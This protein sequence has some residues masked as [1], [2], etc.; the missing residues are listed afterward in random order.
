MRRGIISDSLEGKE[1][2]LEV[3]VMR[4]K[5][6]RRIIFVLV[7]LL[8][9]SLCF[10]EAS[11][12]RKRSK[13]SRRVTNPVTVTPVAEPQQPGSE[14]QII[15]TADQQATGQNDASDA[16]GQA[17]KKSQRTS[18]P[19]PLPQQENE[20]DSMRRTVNDLTNQVTKLSEKLSQMESQQRTLVDLERL[21]RAEQRAE[22]LR[23]QLRDVQEKEANLQ[24]R[25]EQLEIELK[26]ENINISGAT[27]GST[28]PEEVRE[29]RRRLLENE[30]NR[31]QTQLDLMTTSKQRLESAI[32]SADQEVDR[33]RKR[34]DEA[35]EGQ[36]T[37]NSNATEN[38]TENAD[39]TEGTSTTNPPST[40]TPQPSSTPPQP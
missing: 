6:A 11:A 22:N 39:D 20:D 13:R 37:T 28:R 14:P 35:N 10:A 8:S 3:T 18:R 1:K 27:F 7:L 34:I 33:L 5:F 25:K 19:R 16:S 38:T 15:S 36:P 9:V 17:Q 32:Q 31:V 2:A 23:A 12:Q 30:K 26:P 40:N 4:H 21:S 29:T 24:A